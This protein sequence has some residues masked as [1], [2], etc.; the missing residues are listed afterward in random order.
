[1]RCKSGVTFIQRSFRDAQCSLYFFWGGVFEISVNI[2][3]NL[4][5]KLIG[6]DSYS[7]QF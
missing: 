7:R 4:K 5:K 2:L 1:M 6:L 3:K